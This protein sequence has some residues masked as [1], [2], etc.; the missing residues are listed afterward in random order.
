VIRGCLIA[1]LA[2]AAACDDGEPDP[3]SQ[4]R[5]V[6]LAVTDPTFPPEALQPA[7]ILWLSTRAGRAWIQ[8]QEG[9]LLGS[10]VEVAGGEV[11]RSLIVAEDLDPGDN[12]VEVVLA[13]DAGGASLRA[14]AIVGV[15]AMCTRHDHCTPERCVA[16]VCAE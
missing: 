10:Q 6:L 16:Y 1:L 13:P 7:S 11:V 3:P 4:A 15:S 9:H 8:D 5:I 12:S 2:L 14:T